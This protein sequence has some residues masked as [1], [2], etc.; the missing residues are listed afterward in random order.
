MVRK[1]GG[2][3]KKLQL[4]LHQQSKEGTAVGIN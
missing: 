1:L 3:I 4:V 2:A